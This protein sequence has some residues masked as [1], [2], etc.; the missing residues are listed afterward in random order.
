MMSYLKSND[1][2]ASLATETIFKKIPRPIVIADSLSS[3]ENM[4][5]LI[6]LSDNLG[7]QKLYFLGKQPSKHMMKLRRTAASSH[8]NIEWL[9]TDELDLRVLLPKGM[10]LVALETATEATNVFRT[11]LPKN[12]AFIVGSERFGMRNEILRQAD[13][14]VYIPVPGQTRSLNVTHAAAILFFEWLRQRQF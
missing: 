12:V 8:N 11:E 10:K 14:V 5:A 3:A 7:A 6:R 1:L 13:Q 4:G 9:F 2:F